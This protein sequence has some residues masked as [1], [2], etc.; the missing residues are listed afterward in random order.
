MASEGITGPG[1]HRRTSD[2]LFWLVRR[3]IDYL[4]SW[5]IP[6][7]LPSPDAVLAITSPPCP[8]PIAYY[9]VKDDLSLAECERCGYF[10][11]ARTV[12]DAEHATTTPNKEGLAT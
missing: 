3:L 4:A 2:G 5:L 8:G 6:P 12:H 7:P 9:A 11:V 10:T 1:R